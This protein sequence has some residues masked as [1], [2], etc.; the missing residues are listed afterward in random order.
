MLEPL[1]KQPYTRELVGQRIRLVL[2]APVHTPE[3]WSYILRDRAASGSNYSWIESE[4]DVVKYITDKVDLNINDIDYLI[5][6]ADQVIGSFHIHN[7]K[8]G[9]HKAEIGY[10]LEKAQVRH[11]YVSEAL[12]LV[13]AELKRHGFN[14]IVISCNSDNTRSIHVAER[15]GFLKEGL[16]LQDCIEDGIFRDTAVF[17]KLLSK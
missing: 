17:G 13:E 9:D 3:V 6:K 5:F 14:K 7:V 15:N 12:V 16:L 1:K 8:L 10:G 11:G 4:N 2:T